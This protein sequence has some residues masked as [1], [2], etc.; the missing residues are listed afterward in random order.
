MKS[1]VLKVSKKNYNY[2][3]NVN[4]M[5]NI[6]SLNLPMLA[7][8]VYIMFPYYFRKQFHGSH[9]FTV[10]LTYKHNGDCKETYCI[11]KHKC[12]ELQH[13]QTNL[14]PVIKGRNRNVCA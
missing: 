9:K 11:S 1:Q 2:K 3:R 10:A 5:A 4:I 8:P 12:D 7:I 13:S 14:T 6:S